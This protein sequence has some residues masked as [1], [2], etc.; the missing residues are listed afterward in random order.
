MYKQADSCGQRV[1]FFLFK[2]LMK[3]KKERERRNSVAGLFTIK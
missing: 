3:W 1:G 2:F